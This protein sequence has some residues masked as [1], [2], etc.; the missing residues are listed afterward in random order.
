MISLRKSL[1]NFIKQ[2]WR[3]GEFKGGVLVGTDLY[4]NEYYEIPNFQS[5]TSNNY[6]SRYVVYKKSNFDASQVPAEW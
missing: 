1:F 5:D 3:M 6:Q 4:G 2:Y